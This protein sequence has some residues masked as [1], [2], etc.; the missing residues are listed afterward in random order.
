MQIAGS[1]DLTVRSRWRFAVRCA[2]NREES[3]RSSVHSVSS[4]LIRLPME[5][6]VPH[7]LEITV[8]IVCSPLSQLFLFL[9]IDFLP[10][11]AGLR[12]GILLFSSAIEFIV[13]FRSKINI[14]ADII[15]VNFLIS[16]T[17]LD[18]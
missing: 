17:G 7:S 16:D 6:Q 11:G 3:R 10:A 2:Q 13:G 1:A 4:Q 15:E 9:E 8:S 14:C 5:L 18:L 12:I